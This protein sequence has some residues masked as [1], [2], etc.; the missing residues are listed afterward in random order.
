MNVAAAESVPQPLWVGFEV[1]RYDPKQPL[2]IDPVL[3]Y[4][5]YLGGSNYDFG[6]GIAVDD[7]GIVYVTGRTYSTNFPTHNAP[8]R[9]FAGGVDDAFI[10]KLNAG[11]TALVYATYLGGSGSDS[12]LGI[13]VDSAGNAYVTGET[14]SPDFPTPNALDP[15]LGG[16]RDAFI[17]KLN[18]DGTVLV[19]STYLGGT[20]RDYGYGIA[21][22]SAGNAYV[23]GETWSANFPTTSNALD[24][25]L[26]GTWDAFIAKLNA[27]GTALVYATYLGGSDY[28]EGWSIVVDSA[29]NA[30]VTGE[31]SSVNFPTTAN[32]LDPNLGGA[33]D[34]FIVKL[35]AIG[36][37]LVYSTYLGGSNSDESLGIAVDSTGN[38]YVTGGTYS[39]DFP[40]RNA[41][42]LN[43]SGGRDIFIAKLNAGGTALVY[44]TYLGGSKD[45][46]GSGIAV[47]GAGN[48]Y[49]TG[50]TY[51]TNLP[52]GNALY[53][54]FV[55]GVYDAFIA[56]LNA[57]GTGLVYATYLGGSGYDEGLGIALDGAGNAYVTGETES[58]NFPTT[59]NVLDP[60]LGGTGNAFIAKIADESSISATLTVNVIGS[61]T[62]YS[63]PGGINCGATC[64]ASFPSGTTVM[65][66]ATPASNYVF[67]GWGGACIGVTTDYCTLTNF[68][69]LVP[70]TAYFAIHTPEQT[71]PS[72]PTVGVTCPATGGGICS[73]T[74]TKAVV[75]THG[76]NA[77]AFDWVEEMAQA[78]C[79]RLQATQYYHDRQVDNLMLICSGNDWDV[80]TKD[81]NTVATA[82]ALPT[83]V[84]TFADNVG[85]GVAKLLE[86]YQYQHVHFI[87]HSA[88]SRLIAEA[89]KRI[90][91]SRGDAVTLHQTFLDAFDP[92]A[93]LLPNALNGRHLSLLGASAYS[94]GKYWADNYVDT[95]PL[96]RTGDPAWD[97]ELAKIM[98]LAVAAVAGNALLDTTDSHL[99]FAFNI[100]VTSDNDGCGPICR[101]SRPY[102]FY[103]N[104]L[105]SNFHGN[106]SGTVDPVTSTGGMGYPLSLEFGRTLAELTSNFPL[107]KECS[108]TGGLCVQYTPGAWY[109]LPGAAV[110]TIV[111]TTM[112]AVNF[113]EGTG[114]KLFETLQFAVSI[115]TANSLAAPDKVQAAATVATATP[116]WLVA[117]VTT[118]NPTNTLRFNWRYTS[119]GEG[120][121]RVF[122]NENLVSQIDQ[123]DVPLASTEPE[124]V[125]V[126]ELPA[127]TYRIA[128]RLDGYGANASGVELTGVELGQ[129]ELSTAA[130]GVSCN[131]VTRQKFFQPA[132]N[133]YGAPFD[134]FA[135]NAPL[136][137]AKCNIS[138]PH[139]LSVTIGK[140]GD[141]T[142]IAYT[143]GYY[144]NPGISNWSPFTGI[145]N[146]TLNGGW[147][148][149]N[150]TAT[151]TNPNISTA[152]A[153]AP[154]YFVGMVC[155]VQG[156]QWRCGCRD[157]TCTNFYWMLQGA[158]Q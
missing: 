152:S 121:L 87:A 141:S 150:I 79:R 29:G 84:W 104:S 117:Q 82:W 120:L 102:R 18:I 95:R 2:V 144:Y 5:T 57:G 83:L 40:T 43:Y 22:D 4:S 24:S 97:A 33:S 107:S 61:G 118:T 3:V 108:F 133:A 157:T 86:P 70:V 100:D 101:H 62:V 49:V 31:T 56:K 92:L 58:A 68:T 105:D 103:G 30:Y 28:D 46:W 38:V 135:A 111:D 42:Y 64:S 11:G 143:K 60:N 12:G 8:Y 137:D 45:E 112:G 98:P 147:C 32:V 23:T 142:R 77:H 94:A 134:L 26:G 140:V 99:S 16:D 125:Y 66:T 132:Y 106:G 15:N 114:A 65:L 20:Y 9:Q 146:G 74:S 81:W 153:N 54:Q 116:A 149:G 59:A 151:I 72:R 156:G 129:Q 37:A 91:K 122:V 53:P 75:I 145:C 93:R 126:G 109:Y 158:G 124:S 36:T 48:A 27:G 44:S 25:N 55:G 67:S 90:R 39:N 78:M 88:G 14:Q 34:A 17:V 19:Y 139:T 47:D 89:A 130:A 52:T 76:W 50:R 73:T 13:A 71:D 69:T 35:N 115:P 96:A 110:D 6:N 154:T 41:P 119:G 155:S 85:R 136:V 138:D 148:A 131:T 10:A 113:V 21:V 63:T 127:G 128:F 80:W 51:S 123:R 1:A 7:A